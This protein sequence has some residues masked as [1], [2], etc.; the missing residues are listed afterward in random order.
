M[1]DKAESA[2]STQSATTVFERTEDTIKEVFTVLWSDLP[3]W[4]QDNPFIHRGY[5]PPSHSYLKSVASIG[6]LHNESVNIWTHLF[7]ALAAALAGCVLYFSVRPRYHLATQEDVAV[8]SCYFVGAVVCLGMS[9]AYHTISN[10]SEAVAKFGNRLDYVG[11]IALI[12]GS[13]IPSIYYGFSLEPELRKLYWS[14]VSRPLLYMPG[15]IA[16]TSW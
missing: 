3:S 14:M 16:S 2:M 7:G 12:W 10:H 6:A 1:D 9:A 13:F 5:R 11:I 8:F 4:L 15:G